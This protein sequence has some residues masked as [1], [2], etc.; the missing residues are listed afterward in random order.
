[1]FQIECDFDL[2]YF[3]VVEL[4]LIFNLPSYFEKIKVGL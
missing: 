3:Q 1:M 2:C 4:S